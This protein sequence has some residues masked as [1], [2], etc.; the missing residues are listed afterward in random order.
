MLMFHRINFFSLSFYPRAA[1]A[2]MNKKMTEHTYSFDRYEIQQK[3]LINSRLISK[4]VKQAI[5]KKKKTHQIIFS[6]LGVPQHLQ[7]GKL[8]QTLMSYLSHSWRW[9]S[10]EQPGSSSEHGGHMLSV[11]TLSFNLTFSPT[12]DWMHK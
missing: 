2:S 5:E 3:K 1:C 4:W 8:H 9:F 12:Y 11:I 10:A 7:L 6:P